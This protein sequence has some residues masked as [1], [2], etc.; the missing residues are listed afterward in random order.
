MVEVGTSGCEERITS[1]KRV[2]GGP[3]SHGGI[4][5]S[6]R[7]KTVCTLSMFPHDPLILTSVCRGRLGQL[8]TQATGHCGCFRPTSTRN[9]PCPDIGDMIMRMYLDMAEVG[10]KWHPVDR[11]HD[12]A[13]RKELVL[14]P[15]NAVR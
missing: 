12:E 3:G 7:D 2:A 15:L 14:A 8:R 4:V 13:L 9:D 1:A 5:A 11:T 10:V 6:S